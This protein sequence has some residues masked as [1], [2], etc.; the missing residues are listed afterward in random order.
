MLA[1]GMELFVDFFELAVFDLRV[2]LRCLNVG[3]SQHLLDQSQVG[4]AC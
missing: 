3:V 1:S 2:D 4:S